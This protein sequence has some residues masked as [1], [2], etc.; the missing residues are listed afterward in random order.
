[1]DFLSEIYFFKIITEI[2]ENVID[3]NS[4]L[5][6]IISQK[7]E[8]FNMQKITKFRIVIDNSE[9]GNV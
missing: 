2:N 9:C 5:F 1:M 7:R 6:L 8:L 4:S 3:M